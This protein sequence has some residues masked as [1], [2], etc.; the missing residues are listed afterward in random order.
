[1][2]SSLAIIAGAMSLALWGLLATSCADSSATD[3]THRMGAPGKDREMK[4]SEHPGSSSP[5]T[6]EGTHRMGPAGKDRQMKDSEH[7]R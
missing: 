5:S 3:G 6:A 4:D 2:K 1:M 7:N